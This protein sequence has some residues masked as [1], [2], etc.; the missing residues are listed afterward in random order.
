MIDRPERLPE[1]YQL[2]EVIGSGGMGKVYRAHDATLGITDELVQTSE[3]LRGQ[4]IVPASQNLIEH[5]A[6]TRR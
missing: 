3:M 1:R 4:P 2:K 5:S 6:A